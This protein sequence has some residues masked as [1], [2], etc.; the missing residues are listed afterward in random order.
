MTIVT[1]ILI[2]FKCKYSEM[3]HLSGLDPGDSFKLFKGNEEK[4]DNSDLIGPHAITSA[5]RDID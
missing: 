2:S 3:S 4:M 5:L 1:V